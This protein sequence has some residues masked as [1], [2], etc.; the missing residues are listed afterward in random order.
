MKGNAAITRKSL[1]E[2]GFRVY[3]TN[4]S[5]CC[6]VTMKNQQPGKCWNPTADDLV[7]DDWEVIREEIRKYEAKKK[8]YQSI[9]MNNGKILTGKVIG[10]LVAEIVNKFSEA[11]LSYDEAKIV[12]DTV[13][14]NIGE[15][16]TIQEIF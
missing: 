4:S 6:Y 15:Y 12:L 7:A 9:Q 2:Y 11:G 8:T 13:K 14:D 5:E 16:S 3:P 10:E 1:K